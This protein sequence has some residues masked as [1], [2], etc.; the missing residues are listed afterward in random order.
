MI[1]VLDWTNVQ[2]FIKLLLDFVIHYNRYECLQ[3]APLRFVNI[4]I[5]NSILLS[6]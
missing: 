1:Y 5:L 3:M 4:Q 6:H 2:V